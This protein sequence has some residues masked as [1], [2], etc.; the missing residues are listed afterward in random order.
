VTQTVLAPA[1]E[2]EADEVSKLSSI[3]EVEQHIDRLQEIAE[4]H[5]S[6]LVHTA[7]DIGIALRRGREL[8]KLDKRKGF[9]D[10]A[11]DRWGYKHA[12]VQRLMTLAD[13]LNVPRVG[14]LLEE[15]PDLS[16]RRLMGIIDEE[17]RERGTPGPRQYNAP[18]AGTPDDVLLKVLD[19]RQPL[20]ADD[21][22][23]AFI[24][25]GVDLVVTSWPYCLGQDTA[26][27]VDFVDYGEWLQA[28]QDWAYRLAEVLGPNG[29]VAI[30]LP[31]DIR[32]G[33]PHPQP[34]GADGLEILR[35]AGLEYQAAIVWSKAAGG[36]KSNTVARGSVGSPNAPAVASGA[37]FIWV[38]HKG[39]WNL[40]RPREAHDLGPE[41]LEWTNGEWTIA[42]ETDRRYPHVM[43]RTLADRLIRLFSYPGDLVA[44]FHCGRGTTAVAAAL[45]GRRFVGGD[46]N[47]YAVGLATNT[48]N[49]A[50]EAAHEINGRAP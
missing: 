38:L 37:E 46:I 22:L 5:G 20:R 8:F 42:G 7:L 18:I 30:N 23:E 16:V 47:P 19:A 9:R 25:E 36:Q 45:V 4:T 34:I 50:L 28:A 49:T 43:P 13:P 39:E 44:D 10:W 24:G 2:D 48:L 31:I 27:Y 33:Q 26:G 35:R 12:H 40:G 1:L 29:R 6:D 11:T 15:D 17:T 3:G 41:S 32:K 21:E 14:R